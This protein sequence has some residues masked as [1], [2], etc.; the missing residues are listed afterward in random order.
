MAGLLLWGGLQP[1][2]SENWLLGFIRRWGINEEDEEE[3]EDDEEGNE[4][5]N[6]VT[7]PEEETPD[8]NLEVGED[9][10][11]RVI[12]LGVTLAVVRLLSKKEGYHS[13][14]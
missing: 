13:P 6:E 14:L 7:P 5:G 2:H 11:G 3:E 10:L 9:N 4:E 12:L 1:I 8:T